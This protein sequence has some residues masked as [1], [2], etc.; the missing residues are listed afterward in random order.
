[1]PHSSVP[2]IRI[3]PVEGTDRYIAV[4][5]SD[6]LDATFS[7]VF[8]ESVAGAVA[9]HSFAE[10]IR[11]RYEA[12]PQISVVDAFPDNIAVA[13][14]LAGLGNPLVGRS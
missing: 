13:D 12:A 1:M 10:M 5:S 6:A 9:L 11:L 7:V 8:S 2:H 14:V 3:A 4:F